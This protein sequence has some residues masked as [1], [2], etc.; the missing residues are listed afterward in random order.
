[1]LAELDAVPLSTDD[2]LRIDE[3]RL[4]EEL[5]AAAAARQAR[6]TAEFAASQRAAQSTA[7]V[8][9]ER[10]GQGVARQGGCP[11]AARRIR[12]G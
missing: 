11:G 8:P 1:M 2:A 3:I 9:A 10:V 6:I 7:G 4:L 5:K 12:W